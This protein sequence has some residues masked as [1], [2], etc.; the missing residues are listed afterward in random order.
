LAISSAI[1]LY[2]LV[3]LESNVVYGEGALVKGARR[4]ARDFFFIVKTDY[5]N[6]I[7]GRVGFVKED[8]TR[9]EVTGALSSR[10]AGEF[11][12]RLIFAGR[13]CASFLFREL[14]AT[15]V[16]AVIDSVLKLLEDVDFRGR[17]EVV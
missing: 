6:S 16:C 3:F 10:G 17:A 5:R 11:E 14:V 9:R 1:A 7:R 4:W 8:A 13:F 12:K 15:S 2:Y